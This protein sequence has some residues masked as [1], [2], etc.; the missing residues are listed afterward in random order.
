[1]PIPPIFFSLDVNWLMEDPI[2]ESF[3]QFHHYGKKLQR[4]IGRG[5]FLRLFLFAVSISL[6]NV[7]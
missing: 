2:L 6:G 5:Y 3:R 4:H 1:M 7:G